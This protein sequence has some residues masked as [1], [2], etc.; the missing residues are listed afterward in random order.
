[1]PT[2]G[3]VR[4]DALEAFLEGTEQVPERAAAAPPVFV[5]PFCSKALI[6]PRQLQDHIASDH[7]IERPVLLV[8]GMEPVKDQVIRVRHRPADF[9]VTNVTDVA[10]TVDGQ[11]RSVDSF[12]EVAR[13]LAELRQGNV[14][15]NLANGSERI[16]APVISSYKLSFRIATGG[17]LQLVERAFVATMVDR[18]LSM[19]L[20]NIFLADPRCNGPAR[21]YAEA[22]AQYVVGVLVKERPDGQM[23]T[24]PFSRYRELFGSAL[25]ALAPH[26]RPYARLLCAVMQFALNDI[27]TMNP[28]S[29]F[30]ELDLATAMLRGPDFKWILPPKRTS[31][32]RVKACPIDH[33]TGRI[34]DF[35]VRLAEQRR[36][37]ALLQDECQQIA[38]SDALDNLDRQKALAIWAV[39]ALR[40]GAKH[41]AAEPL[42]QLSAT[43]PFASW[44]GP[45]SETVKT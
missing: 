31:D 2:Y 12:D 5:C 10:L 43:Y 9:V 3:W 33:G 41:A 40:L 15:L 6:T 35:A 14:A 18:D 25:E 29:G 27:N 24:S 16:S 34:L 20:V 23:I 45:I 19:P 4:E 11:E 1:M 26:P 13:E 42:V 32:P 28:N 30:W 37:S 8:D 39:T 17:A 22:M 7:R 38:K 44:A 21:D 36:W